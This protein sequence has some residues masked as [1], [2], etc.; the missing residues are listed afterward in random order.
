[1]VVPLRLLDCLGLPVPSDFETADCVGFVAVAEVFFGFV[2]ALH[3]L[4]RTV[5]D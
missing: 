4:R 2:E 5:G 3:D 1:M